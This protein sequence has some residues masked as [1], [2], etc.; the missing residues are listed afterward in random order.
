LND[1]KEYLCSCGRIAEVVSDGKLMC[2]EL[3]LIDA[4]VKWHDKYKG[5]KARHNKNPAKGKEIT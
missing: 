1:K 3:Y 5:Q 4:P 2:W